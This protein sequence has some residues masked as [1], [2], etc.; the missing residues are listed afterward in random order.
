MPHPTIRRE[1][2]DVPA[3]SAGACAVCNATLDDRITVRLVCSSLHACRSCGCWTYLPR[4]SVAGQAA[5]HD[6]ED[7]FDHP[8]FKLRRIVTP[9]QRRRC[10]D[11]FARLSVAVDITS[12]RGEC[13]LDI[14]CDTGT[15]LKAAQEEIGISPVGLDLSERAVQ[16]AR[17]QGIRAYRAQ[18]EEAPPEVTGFR[19]A[20]AIDLIEHVLDPAG[21]LRQTRRRLHPGGVLYLE[22][23]N[24][25]SMV[26]R[27]GKILSG[28]TAGRPVALFERLFPPQHIQYFTPEGLQQLAERAGFEVVQLDT[29]V[30]RAS[31]IA[32]SLAAL[33]PIELLQ[34]CDRLLRTGILVFAIL[35]RPLEAST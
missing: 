14:G 18:I 31:D 26:Y 33:V 3:G 15:F 35:R 23:P 16:V 21:F 19:V 11:V 6:S 9:S 4:A 12:L 30:L 32:A 20:T 13:L 7:Y 28:L 27:F 34:A 5:I 29:R 22:T 1:E 24:I 25:R 2:L 8:Y 10:R 17:T